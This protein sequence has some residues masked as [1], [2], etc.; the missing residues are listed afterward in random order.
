M[1]LVSNS[2]RSLQNM[3]VSKSCLWP[4][5]TPR[6]WP[7]LLGSPIGFPQWLLQKYRWPSPRVGG[8]PALVFP[9]PF[10]PAVLRESN[11][12][13]FY[14]MHITLVTPALQNQLVL[15]DRVR[16]QRWL[17]PQWPLRPVQHVS[18]AAT[19]G[20]PMTAAADFRTRPLPQRE[21]FARQNAP[22]PWQPPIPA[23]V[24]V[25]RSIT[26]RQTQTAVNTV[27]VVHPELWRFP[28]PTPPW[29]GRFESPNGPSH[30]PKMQ[31]HTAFPVLLLTTGTWPQPVRRTRPVQ[32][33]ADPSYFV[34]LTSS[35]SLPTTSR[36]S[37]QALLPL[38]QA[39]R[40][41]TFPALLPAAST[42]SVARIFPQSGQSEAGTGFP[43]RAQ[44][45]V[46]LSYVLSAASTVARPE[47]RQEAADWFVPPIG[48]QSAPT[49][50]QV[51]GI[52]VNRLTEQVAQ[53]LERKIRLEK[54]RRGYR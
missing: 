45:P 2:R 24:L 41:T 26:Y 5:R 51:P 8:F 1:D 37:S 11:N 19:P 35:Q 20:W 48:R 17:P 42:L 13:F 6:P 15:R 3:Q 25:A 36:A 28:A 39:Q 44:R 33:E 46:D 40:P 27:K 23:Q 14:A 34:P 50:A 52:D 43:P 4:D 22:W 10:Q 9:R 31:R 29:V 49:P 54:Q 7:L 21:S 16:H 47:Q 53:A 30:V 18:T 38:D 12:S 32:P